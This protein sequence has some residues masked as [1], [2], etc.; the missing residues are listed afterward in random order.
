M[1]K[2]LNGVRIYFEVHGAGEPV[3]LLHGFSGSSQDWNSVG[4]Q[5]AESFRLVVPD[6]RGHGRSDVLSSPPPAM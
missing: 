6:L 4:A 5:W 3:V 2:T 1:I